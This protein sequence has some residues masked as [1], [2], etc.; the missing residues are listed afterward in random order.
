MVACGSV[1]EIGTDLRA[2]VESGGIRGP[3]YFIRGYFVRC[4]GG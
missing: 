3:K 2:A 4:P 1:A